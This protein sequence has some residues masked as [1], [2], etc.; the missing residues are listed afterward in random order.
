MPLIQA[1][2]SALKGSIPPGEMIDKPK[3][4]EYAHLSYAIWRF[5][6][7]WSFNGKIGPDEAVLFRQIGRWQPRK[8]FLE[9]VP[10]ELSDFSKLADFEITPAGHLYATPFRPSWLQ[11]NAIDE[12]FGIDPRPEERRCDESFPAEPYLHFLGYPRW[13]SQAQK[14]ATWMMLRA[15]SGSTS[16]VALPTGSGKSL[17]FQAV[18]RFST[19]V[20]IVIVPTVALAIDQ[21]RSASEVVKDIPNLKPLYYASDDPTLDPVLV[22]E[23]IREGETRLV[24]TSPEACVSGRLRSLIEELAMAGRLSNLV[25]D[26]AHMIETWGMFFRVDFQLLSSLRRKWLAMSGN[27]FRTFL[28]SATFTPQTRTVLENLFGGEGKWL[29]LVSQRLRPEIN[30]FRQLFNDENKRDSALL[31]C[32][33]RLPRPAIFYTTEVEE[34]RRLFAKLR[35][36]GFLRTG[37]FTGETRAVDRRK[38]LDDWRSDRIDVMVAT[39][40]FGLGVDKADV[41]SVVHACLPE[42]PHRYYQEVG[43][44]GRDGNSSIAVLLPTKKDIVVAKGMAPKMLSREI[45]QERWE[46]LWQSATPVANE[47]H[48]YRINTAARRTELK[49]IRTYKENIRWNKRFLLQLLRAGKLDILDIDYVPSNLLSDDMDEWVKVRL[50]FSPEAPNIAESIDDMRQREVK[51]ATDDLEQILSYV[52][53]D[54]SICRMLKKLYGPDVQRVCSGCPNCRIDGLPYKYCDHL[55]FDAR[56]SVKSNHTIITDVVDLLEP[57]SSIQTRN[58]LRQLV[59]HYGLRRFATAP[60][61]VAHLQ[62]LFESA[63]SKTA[64][65]LYR[66]DVFDA[67]HPVIFSSERLAVF[68]IRKFDSRTKLLQ[69]GSEVFDFVC[70]GVQVI[71]S[72]GRFFG[73]AD[74]WKLYNGIERW[75]TETKTHVY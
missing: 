33:W 3:G 49:G 51:V 34:A 43:R 70:K 24:F 29:E 13:Q 44:G 1:L 42:N 57:R 4:E 27:S 67:S 53:R 23:R 71:D 22:A 19:G 60:E 74:G 14:E 16:L 56:D 15:P 75:M 37:C 55:E 10:D 38:L 12:K 35:S 40:A 66:L 26:E 32:A 18:A 7:S 17:C 50:R 21:W 41:R 8:L 6:Q 69:T 48:V 5:L 36:V 73:E 61:Y 52:S 11:N 46:A 58:I 63:F 59:Q 62:T 45:A 30:Y 47:D 54:K 2:R 20:T 65:D 39:S 72:S 9:S 28:L 25:V 31:D 64:L 68:H